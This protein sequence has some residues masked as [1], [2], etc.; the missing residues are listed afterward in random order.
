MCLILLGWKVHPEYPLIVAA[1]R[2]EFHAR[3]A[4]GAAFWPDQPG[5][6]AGRDLEARG[7]WMGVSRSGKFSAVT[8]YRGAFETR[9]AESRGALATRFLQGDEPADAYIA[10]VWKKADSYS[11]FNLLAADGPSLW[12]MSN[13]GGEPH[14]LDPGVH[15]LGNALLDTPELDPAKAAFTGIVAA[16]PSVDSLF[17]ALAARR[18]L[19][20]QYGTRCS[21][22]LRRGRQGLRYAERSFDPAGEE[23]ET[24][25]FDLP[26]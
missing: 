21:T 14:R 9:A 3:P 23:R 2:D 11:G 7:T 15:G 1:N 24:L 26:G 20:P 4:A 25:Q 5:I 13:R 16:G 8:N 22:V 12:W 19:N 18:I 6:L 17:E 10:S